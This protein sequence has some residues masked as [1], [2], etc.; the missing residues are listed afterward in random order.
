MCFVKLSI[1]VFLLRLAAAQ[2]V[3]TWILRISIFVVTV[4]SLTI[5]FWNIFQ[6][7]P[8]DKQW[9]YR[10]TGGSCVPP[11]EIV[12]AAYAMTALTILSDWLFVSFAPFTLGRRDIL[13]REGGRERECVF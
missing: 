12:S 8:V 1:G 4:W 6:C 3:Y 7:S 5:F 10:I 13:K 9:D 2:K 11:A